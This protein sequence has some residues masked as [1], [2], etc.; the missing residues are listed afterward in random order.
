LLADGRLRDDLDRHLVGCREPATV[1]ADLEAQLASNAAA[2]AAL[3]ALGGAGLVAAWARH[4][5]DVADEAVAE[6]LPALPEEAEARD[7]LEGIPLVLRLSRVGG[8]LRVDLTGTGGPHPGNLNA[9][10]AVVRAAVLYALRVL[11]DRPLPLNEGAFRR[12][13]LVLPPGSIVDP[14][15]GV[16]VAGGNV[17][18]SQRVV[19]L[20]L[21]AAGRLAASAGTMSNL[22]VGGE[23]WSLY[24]TVG[25][26][27]GASARGPGPSGRQLHMTNTR[28]TDP[29]VLESR[30]PL[31]VRRFGLR[32]GS[33]GSG[34]HP[35]G[36]GLVRELE[37]LCPAVASLLCT[38]RD[39]G[40]PGLAGGGAGAPGIDRVVVGGAE[41]PWDG[42]PEALSPGDRVRVGTPGGGGWGPSLVGSRPEAP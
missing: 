36:E 35:G 24:E 5:Q 22:T 8:R 39:R 13:D 33:G 26:G 16:A 25:G 21:V 20:M 10:P 27:Q 40:A 38:R 17:E 2:R 29:E 11:A 23:G 7:A 6:L 42:S 3:K 1:R 41:R 37:V 15:P 14:P 34:R 19:D 28:A 32:A 31:R 4:L 12:V 9:P 30:L 18:T